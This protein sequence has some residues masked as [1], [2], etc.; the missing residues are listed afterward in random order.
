VSAVGDYDRAIRLLREAQTVTGSRQYTIADL[1]AAF[2]GRARALDWLGRHTEALADWKSALGY[3]KTRNAPANELLAAKAMTLAKLG[4][5]AEA[6]PLISQVAA[7]PVDEGE[8]FFVAATAAA[9]LAG[10][11]ADSVERQEKA[12]AQGTE[13]LR[14]A[15]EAGLFRIKYWANRLKSDRDLASL[16]DRADYRQLVAELEKKSAPVSQPEL[17]PAPRP[18]P[19]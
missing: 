12:Q 3:A 14:R 10:A 7:A 5:R 2:R 16:R 17:T 11:D 19:R 6:E 4:R 13:L 9:L 8:A 15:H 18:A 1:E